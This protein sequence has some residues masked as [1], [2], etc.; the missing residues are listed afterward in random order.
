[1]EEND[2]IASQRPFLQRSVSKF[3]GCPNTMEEIR[4]VYITRD[5][6]HAVQHEDRNELKTCSVH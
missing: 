4:V 5:E 3:S 6:F 1:M 2:L